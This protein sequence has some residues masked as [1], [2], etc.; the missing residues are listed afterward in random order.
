MEPRLMTEIRHIS[1]AMMAAAAML[2]FTGNRNECRWG[3]CRRNWHICTP[4]GAVLVVYFP[5]LYLQ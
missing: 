1:V 4:Y 5:C 2:N 3:E